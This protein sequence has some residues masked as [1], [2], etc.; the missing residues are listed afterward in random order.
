MAV[1][2]NKIRFKDVAGLQ[3]EKEELVEVVE[4]LKDPEKFNKEFKVF[5]R[6][7]GTED[8]YFN[9]FDGDDK[10]LEGKGLNMIRE[11]YPGGH[12]WTVWR[13]CIHS[14]LPKIFQN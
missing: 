13:R 9:A 7:M 6:A 2:G 4:F 14:F 8:Q 12:D 5:Y 11:T 3:E 1:R 10:F